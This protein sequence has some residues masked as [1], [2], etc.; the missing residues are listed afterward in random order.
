[1]Q[2][3]ASAARV[4]GTGVVGLCHVV[5]MGQFVAAKVVRLPVAARAAGE[6]PAP[7]RKAGFPASRLR[8]FL[9][10][11][12]PG[13]Q[14][15]RALAWPASPIPVTST[16]P[17]RQPVYAGTA[18]SSA[19][20]AA[21]GHLPLPDRPSVPA[22]SSTRQA[23]ASAEAGVFA[24]NRRLVARKERGTHVAWSSLP[25]PPPPLA[26]AFA[27]EVWPAPECDEPPPPDSATQPHL[28]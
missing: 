14:P 21:A 6:I 2:V 11:P 23:V 18:R 28:L 13:P 24:T 12:I 25:M 3:V 5:N 9:M 19:S 27:R 26:P 17:A 15:A 22:V 7:A 10:H 8:S 20:V 4:S 16:A 1:M